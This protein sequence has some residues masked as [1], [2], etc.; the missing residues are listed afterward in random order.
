MPPL[1]GMSVYT[2]DPQGLLSA[3]PD[4]KIPPS[5][6]LLYSNITAKT[7]HPNVIIILFV[8]LKCNVFFG[9]M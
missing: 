9:Y 6:L 7:F 3:K 5:K 2:S 1:G 8:K 4:N